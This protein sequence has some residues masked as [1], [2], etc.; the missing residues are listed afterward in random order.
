[1]RFHL[2]LYVLFILQ[3]IHPLEPLVIKDQGQVIAEM[4]QSDYTIP[5]VALVDDIKVNVLMDDLD[6]QVYRA[7]SNAV[8]DGGGRIISEKIGRQLNRTKFKEQVYSYIFE[9]S[10][11]TLDVPLRNVH[12]R[13]D[14][15]LLESI[16][17]K[18]IGNYYT[19]Y[20]ANN[21][22]RSQNIGL[23]AKAINNVVIFPEETF[24]FNTVVGKRTKEKGYLRAPIIVRGEASED[25]GGGI[26]QISSTL[27]NAVDRAGLEIIQRYSHSKNVPYVPPGRDA[28]VSWYG[29]DFSF[30]NKYNQ[31]I[32]I[33]AFAH[34]GQV[35]IM[36]SSS[37]MI[38][39]KPREVP[40]ASKKIPEEI[41]T[42]LNANHM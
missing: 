29:P 4:N 10:F 39:N 1:M 38:D 14:S 12:P 31:P 21:K 8:I 20:N 3:Q 2:I 9:G 11:T 22:N 28:T 25:I 17:A 36:I 5:G 33:R 35:S 42:D 37:D 7:P 13:V 16:M 18:K 24:S 27:Y 40:S 23:A 41:T 32:L 19:Y 6:K 15:E 30:K 26:C 34:G